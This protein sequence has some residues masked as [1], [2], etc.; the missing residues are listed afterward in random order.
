[1]INRHYVVCDTC[2][3]PHTLR[4]QVGHDDYQEHSFA[5]TDC[6]EQMVVG[7]HCDQ[8][9][10]T[11]RIVEKENCSRGDAEG[12]VINL[13]PD[14]PISSADLHQ[15]LAFPSGPHVLRLLAAQAALGARPI[16]A[17]DFLKVASD[18]L[19]H[20]PSV[21]WPILD[22]AW[23]LHRRGRADLAQ[24]KVDEYFGEDDSSRSIYEAIFDFCIRMLSPA[25]TPLFKDAAKF[26]SEA[27]RAHRDE[28]S[29]FLNYLAG[30][31]HR[32]NLERAHETLKEYF[33]SY[34]DFSQLLTH[35]RHGVD[36]SHD[37][38]ASSVAFSKTK[39]FYGNAYENLTTNIATLALL[40]NIHAGRKFDEFMAMSLSK[41]LQSN[42]A[43]RANPFS[44]VE[45]LAEICVPLNSTI[46]NASH[47]GAMRI[48]NDGRAIQYRSGSSGEQKT[49]RYL[50]YINA[51]N[52]IMLSTCALLALELLI[53]KQA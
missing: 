9:N 45:A 39:L 47:H 18:A 29:S 3:T 22:K 16:P 28:F 6:G 37:Y 27:L 19:N 48:I 10:A 40:N 21:L 33:S 44:A 7:M 42:K 2:A 20:R 14:F 31:A 46:R 50:E 25:R 51:C 13:S 17:G 5:C 36:V 26:S 24:A 1:M 49:M 52:E 35:A 43:S 4:I 32:D 53:M 34:T 38:E 11:L 30:G 23:S 41:Y 12:M 15:D 8:I